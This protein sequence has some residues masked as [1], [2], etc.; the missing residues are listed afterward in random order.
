MTTKKK[1]KGER[2]K[3]TSTM[4]D[5]KRHLNLGAIVKPIKCENL[6]FDESEEVREEKKLRKRR[7]RKEKVVRM[8]SAFLHT[9]T[10]NNFE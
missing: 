1:Q 4:D 5:Y 6:L 8:T 3:I 7:R 10:C 2:E 9:H